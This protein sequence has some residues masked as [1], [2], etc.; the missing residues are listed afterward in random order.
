MTKPRIAIIGAGTAGCGCARRAA[1]LGASEVIL[2]DRETPAAGSSSRSAGVYNAQ[3][4]DPLHIEIR[5]RARE[6]LFR[7]ND[8]GKLPLAKIGNLRP[9]RTEDD[10]AAFAAAIDLQRELGADDGQLL[11]PA[12]IKRIIPDLN[13]DGISGGL[14]GPNDGHLD[15]YLLCTAM[16]DEAKEHGARLLSQA[17]VTGHSRRKGEHVLQTTQGEVVCD[18]VVNAGGAWAGQIGEMLG[19]P[20]GIKPQ[21]HEVIQVKL[22]RHLGYDVPMVNTYVPGQAGEGIY[23][24]QDGPDSMIAGLHSYE[25][26]EGLDVADPDAFGPS[27]GDDYLVKVATLVSERLQVEGMGFKYGWCGL[28]PIS[29]DGQFQVGPYAADPSVV[30]V[31][32]MGGVGVVSG[33]ILGALAAE[34]IVLGKPTTLSAA[35]VECLLPDRSDLA[36]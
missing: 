2:I 20:A 27:E 7:L 13:L 30:A 5:V 32:G 34:W 15:G 21:L 31:A 33:T 23:F 35:T 11:D 17:R 10:L 18:V 24:R 12:G 14:Y 29:A 8:A 36:P 25:A 3:T 19:H 16:V 26:V 9:G 6:L 22:P 1:E 4:I 28:Y